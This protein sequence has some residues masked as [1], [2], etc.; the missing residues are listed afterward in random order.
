M[1]SLYLFFL[2]IYLESWWILFV[3]NLRIVCKKKEN[4]S[5][6]S[7]QALLFYRFCVF[8]KDKT[9][10]N[11]DFGYDTEV[12]VNKLVLNWSSPLFNFKDIRLIKN[13]VYSV[14]LMNTLVG[15]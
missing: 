1:I 7:I 5:F 2:Y 9:T 3:L 13:K 11:V 8:S 15:C 4:L 10:L 12:R 6:K 14:I